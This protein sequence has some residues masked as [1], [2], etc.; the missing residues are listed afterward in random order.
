MGNDNNVKWRVSSCR[1]R[2]AAQAALVRAMMRVHESRRAPATFHGHTGWPI[3]I[4]RESCAT[5]P[6]WLHEPL[7]Q[8]ACGSSTTL[9]VAHAPT[10]PSTTKAVN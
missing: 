10:R 9:R 6:N 1:S 7:W 2:R 4:P 8:P 5:T 3:T